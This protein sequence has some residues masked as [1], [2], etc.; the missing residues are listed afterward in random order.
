M[1]GKLKM[2]LTFKQY[3]AQTGS[4]AVYP[5]HIP[6]DLAGVVYCALGLGGEA[7]EVL[8]KIKKLIRDGDSPEKRKA[9]LKEIGDSL[10]YI[11][12]L[13]TE[14]GKFS[15]AECAQDNLDKL[16]GR[17]LRGT[18]HGNGDER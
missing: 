10:W 8:G 13:L 15:M 6:D 4:T 14:L 3:Q 12:Q 18:L 17:K 5:H 2:D 7:G 11:P 16:A 9:I 1:K